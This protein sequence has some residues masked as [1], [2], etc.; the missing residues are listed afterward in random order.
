M[1][2]EKIE[3][4]TQFSLGFIMVSISIITL[5]VGQDLF[6]E[7][8]ALLWAMGAIMFPS[9]GMLVNSITKTINE[10]NSQKNS[11]ANKK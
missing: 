10:R 5:K 1:C 8:A 6:G 7:D 9:M 3:T 4:L 11:K 2:K